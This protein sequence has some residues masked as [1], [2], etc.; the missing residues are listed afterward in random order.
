MRA[1]A[2]LGVLTTHVAFQTATL[3]VPII[4]PI[5][6]RL[7]LAVALFF[8]LS[9]FL[10]WRPYAVAARTDAPPPAVGRYLRHRFVRIWPAYA[11][12]VIAVLLLVP[13]ARGSSA[14]VWIANLTLTQVFVP[15]TL[16][17]GL[18]QMWSLSVEVAFY[19][20][21]PVFGYALIRM[22]GPRAR[23]RVPVL[24]GVAALS[25]AW[26]PVAGLLP[27]QAGVEPHNWVF[28]HLPWFAAGLILAE[29]SASG[30]DARWSANRPVMF[31]VFVVAYGLASTPIAG[32]VGLAPMSDAQYAAKMLLGGIGAYAVLAPLVLGDGRFRF[33]DSPVMAALG[34]WSYGIFVW[35][36][37]I[38][39]SVFGLFGIAAF[40][41]HFVTVWLL[42]AVITVPV[43]A[44]GYAFVE[45]PLRRALKRRE[46][47][48]AEVTAVETA[49]IA[50]N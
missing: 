28:G 38:L 14:T 8:A 42:T 37:A 24:L 9:G 18:T 40:D 22:R 39:A 25:L 44:A 11:V 36:V 46:G 17:P 31:V 48:T 21:L 3:D 2:A 30:V 20:L 29:L 1:V 13:Q 33:L 27:L 50:A 5:L 12:V 43:S 49:T 10:L 45:E 16:A 15:L 34:R 26:G 7:D 47:R 19:L 4:G 23:L 41:G 6:G 35:H 32:P